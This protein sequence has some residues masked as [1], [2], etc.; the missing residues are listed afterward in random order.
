LLQKTLKNTGKTF[1]TDCDVKANIWP[2]SNQKIQANAAKNTLKQNYLS[3]VMT[4]PT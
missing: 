2:K 4:K 3:R 1:T